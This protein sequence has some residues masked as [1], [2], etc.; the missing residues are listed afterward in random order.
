MTYIELADKI[1]EI[2]PEATFDEDNDGQLIIYT[3]LMQKGSDS[4]PLET[5]EPTVNPSANF[6]KEIP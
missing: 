5:F 6:Q 1:K 2:L 4:D 3:D